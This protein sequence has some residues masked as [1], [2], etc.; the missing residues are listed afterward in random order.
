MFELMDIQIHRE[1]R[2]IHNRSL[3]VELFCESTFIDFQVPR[4]SNHRM[5]MAGLFSSLNARHVTSSVKRHDPYS[6]S[7]SCAYPT[8]LLDPLANVSAS[9][10]GQPGQLNV[11][12]IPPPLRHM[13]DS[14][15]Y[16]VAYAMAGSREVQVWII[17]LLTFYLWFFLWWGGGGGGGL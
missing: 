12:W 1:G 8:V 16:E 11:S 4:L 13:D 15:M 5:T 9:A 14:L 2:L 6:P 17:S 7:K 10:T 3:L